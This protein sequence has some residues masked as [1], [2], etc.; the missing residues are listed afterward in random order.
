MNNT[1]IAV[2]CALALGG[3]HT[4]GSVLLNPREKSSVAINPDLLKSCDALP[5]LN[6]GAEVD[7]LSHYRAI[8][9]SNKKCAAEKQSLVDLLCKELFNCSVQ[10][11][12][13][14]K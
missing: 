6:N 10:D 1:F 5:L 9:L 11:T 3:C 12:S 7:V 4:T 14:T 2:L 13:S 8:I